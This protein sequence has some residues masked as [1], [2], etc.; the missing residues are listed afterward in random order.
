M[1]IISQLHSEAMSLKADADKQYVEAQLTKMRAIESYKQSGDRLI[2]LRSLLKTAT[3]N[4]PVETDMG[5]F[6]GWEDYLKRTEWSRSS[7]NE[8][9]TLAENW[10]IVLK[11]GMQDTTNAETVKK[12][13]RLCRTLKIIRWYKEQITAGRPEEELTLDVYW[14]E[15]ENPQSTGPS[16]KQLQAE[17]EHYKQLLDQKDRQIAELQQLLRDGILEPVH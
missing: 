8:Y 15:E 3:K 13:M 17:L 6:T 4:N 2:K 9:I 10:D 16:K 14:L 5:V 11:L 12:C 7:A 1:L